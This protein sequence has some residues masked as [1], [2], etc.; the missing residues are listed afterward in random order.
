MQLK[1]DFSFAEWTNQLVPCILD[2]QVELRVKASLNISYFDQVLYWKV[3]LREQ[4]DNC[5]KLSYK[6][7]NHINPLYICFDPWHLSILSHLNL[8]R[9]QFF[10]RESSPLQNNCYRKSVYLCRLFTTFGSRKEEHEFKAQF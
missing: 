10:P 5:R 9:N 3:I 8:T 6:R 7:M 2:T 1:C 4:I